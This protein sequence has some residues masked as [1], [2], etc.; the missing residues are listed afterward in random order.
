M[1]VFS[2]DQQ[3]SAAVAVYRVKD[4]VSARDADKLLS[5][6][7]LDGDECESLWPMYL[8]GALKGAMQQDFDGFVWA[9]GQIALHRGYEE[10]MAKYWI[11]CAGVRK[12]L[13]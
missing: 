9:M 6:I 10:F 3:A 2:V 4:A 12:A 7:P 11:A 13:D 8:I 5:V 1:T